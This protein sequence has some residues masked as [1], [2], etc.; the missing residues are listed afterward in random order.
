MQLSQFS[1]IQ[2]TAA[3]GTVTITAQS[4]VQYASLVPLLLSLYLILEAEALSYTRCIRLA[5]GCLG[6]FVSAI[7]FGNF[8]SR[9]SRTVTGADGAGEAGV[10]CADL[11]GALLFGTLTVIG[12]WAIDFMAPPQFPPPLFVHPLGLSVRTIKPCLSESLQS[13]CEQRR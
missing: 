3:R 1:E 12:T 11:S 10:N 2:V 4:E 6:P 7:R 8:I 5:W 9:V 13:C